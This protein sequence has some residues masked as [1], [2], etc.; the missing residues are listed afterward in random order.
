MQMQV[1]VF[2]LIITVIFFIIAIF[3]IPTL[4]QL[5]GTAQ[6]ADEF[7]KDAQRDL[8]PMLR[9]MHEASEHLN[10]I[11]KRVD[12]GAEKVSTLMDSVGEIGESIQKVHHAVQHGI[13]RSAGNALGLWLGLRAASKVFLKK[14]QQQ[15]GGK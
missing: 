15:E 3:L 13:G 5:K 9:E 1:D 2:A 4:L 8:L 10:R 7:L 12:E 11:S 6:R 14:I